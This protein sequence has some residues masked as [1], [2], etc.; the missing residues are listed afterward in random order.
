[1]ENRL[2]KNSQ[3]KRKRTMRV[4]RKLRGSTQRPRLCVV[5]SN[6]HL[7]AQII[8]DE[9]GKTIVSLNTKTKSVKEAGFARKGKQAAAY[10]GKQ[11]AVM[12]KE[13]NIEKVIFDRGRFKYHG[14]LAALAD[15]ARE[16]GLQ[17]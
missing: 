8:D 16:E 14:V 12:A 6:L 17:F 2:I 5:K 13:K 1:M 4:R 11:L 3:L 9:T 10:I 7:E 15:A